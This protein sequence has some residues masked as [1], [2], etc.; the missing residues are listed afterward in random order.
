V[1]VDSVYRAS[2]GKLCILTWHVHGNYLYAL[3]H[4]PHEFI[5]PVRKDGRPGYSPL[6]NKIPWGKNI[7][8]IDAEDIVK[9]AFD[10]VIYQSQSVYEDDALQLLT[11]AQRAL[12]S[13]YIEHDPPRPYP[14]D[15]VHCFRHD[16]GVL[17]HVTHYNALNWDAGDMPTRVIEHGV[18]V[19]PRVSYT[20]EHPAGITV[21]NN[22][23][24]RGR[25]MGADLFEWSR[26]RV[27]LDLIGMQSE[28]MGGL[29]EVPNSNVAAT[30][31]PYRFFYTPIRYTSLGL[32]LVEAMLIGMPV[33]GVAAT[34]LPTVIVNGVNGFV[35]TDKERI[36]D[37]M[38]LLIADP[39]LARRWGSAGR[40]TAQER[41][42]MKRFVADWLA[43]IDEVVTGHIETL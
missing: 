14:V 37:V 38:R 42:G 43:V 20:G 39:A 3:S 21:I 1:K 5:I 31:A 16:R 19:D 2:P 17:V 35:H 11:A 13:I 9:E 8:Q 34:E 24:A 4:V 33:V 23:Q 22:L 26:E 40:K 6:G 28:L 18:P 7:R 27:P 10:C 12:P 41:F 15:T 32:A 25:R 36:V 30:M 29:A